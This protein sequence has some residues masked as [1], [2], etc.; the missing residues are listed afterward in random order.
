MAI[1]QELCAALLAGRS[2]AVI[3]ADARGVIRF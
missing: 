2:D 3:A 1:E